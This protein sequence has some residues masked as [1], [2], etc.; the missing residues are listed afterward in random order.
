MFFKHFVEFCGVCP[1]DTDG[2]VVAAG[3]P[4][5]GVA[6]GHDGGGRRVHPDTAR[7]L[8]GRRVPQPQRLGFKKYVSR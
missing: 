5:P 7:L 2:G 1:V 3:D 8:P 4:P 6:D